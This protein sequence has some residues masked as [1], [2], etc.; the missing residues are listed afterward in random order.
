MTVDY[1]SYE[2]LDILL[3]DLDACARQY[4]GYQKMEQRYRSH[5]RQP[6]RTRCTIRHAPTGGRLCEIQG[7]TRNLCRNGIGFICRKVFS[8]GDVVEL[9]INL[10]KRPITYM[11][12]A[13]RFCRYVSQGY[14]E[15]GIELR[16]AGK[17]TIF[18]Q[19]THAIR[20]LFSHYAG[21]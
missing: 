17:E 9:E 6:F 10:P 11:A 13:V 3:N 2:S 7:R 15:I 14:H 16:S 12:G 1:I 8:L 21:A 18:K 4:E 5:P 20:Q 19:D